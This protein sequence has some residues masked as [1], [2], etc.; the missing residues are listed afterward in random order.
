LGL[1]PLLAEKSIFEEAIEQEFLVWN[2]TRKLNIPKN[3]RPKDKRIL[4]WEEM[5]SILA[6][7]ARRDRLLLMLDMTAALHPSELFALRWRSFD[8]RNTLSITE[9]VYRR[10]F[11]RSG[12][13]PGV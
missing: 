9:T 1:G 5:W 4:S 2:P 3:L 13:R 6:K 12:R 8:N 10:N 11:D 7:T